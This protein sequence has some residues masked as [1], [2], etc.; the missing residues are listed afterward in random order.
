MMQTAAAI[1]QQPTLRVGLIWPG[2]NPRTRF[3][4]DEMAEL[5]ASVKAQGVMEP[6]I[7]RPVDDRFEIIAGERRWRAARGVYGE[8]YE[9]PVVY[10]EVDDATASEMAL[11]ENVQRAG[12]G[13]ADEAVEASKILARCDGD[14]D[15]TARR[16]G[17]KRD[18]LD[19]RLALMNC[20]PTV[21]TAM[22]EKKILLGHAE[23]LAA[24]TKPKQDD[25]LGKLFAM[26][27]MPTVAQLK[28][29]LEQIAQPLANVVFDKEECLG[30]H[31]NSGNQRVMF[32][33]SI[34]EGF[35]TNA[36]CYQEKTEAALAVKVETL[37]ETW[38]T[39]KIVRPGEQETI[40]RLVADGA[41]GVGEEQAKACKG[42]EK[43]GAAVS[44]VPGKVGNVYEG[45]CFDMGCNAKKVAARIKSE[46]QAKEPAA[47]AKAATG[48]AAAPGKTKAASTP[49]VQDSQRIKEYREKV[50]RESLHTELAADPGKSLV[51]LIALSVTRNTQ[52]IN[53]SG[54]LEIYGGLDGTKPDTFHVGT[55]AQQVT[56]SDKEVRQ[57]LLFAL[58]PSAMKNVDIN[59]VME[60]LR[61]LEVDLGKHWVFSKEYFDL[62]TKSE[63][64]VVA[65]QTGL[66]AAVGSNF[67]KL[68]GGSKKDLIDALLKID[69]FAYQGTVPANMQWDGAV[70][71]QSHFR[72]VK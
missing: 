67:T 69:G 64:E 11:T 35:C 25:V 70:Q 43:F 34:S 38:P 19:K 33:E 51:V 18:T 16:L 41:T 1:P 26:P 3:D 8:D 39:V 50:W 47:N 40:I 63:I 21:L 61:W 9:I 45:Y 31:H 46:N 30:C 58:A 66:K 14:R 65:E 62:L 48:K 55:V 49:Q 12:M 56:A 10:R 28:A 53:A 5:E 4:P 23:L 32:S 22:T 44:G 37:K 6:I 17:W 71:N 60:L 36:T 2:K 52:H 20:S 57:K 72:A 7:I 54:L 15:E 27:A 24:V 13:P 42:C 29:M 59:T 68:L